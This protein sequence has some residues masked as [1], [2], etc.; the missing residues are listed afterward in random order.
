[1]AQQP[2]QPATRDFQDIL[3]DLDEGRVHSH[4]TEH[5]R[6]VV[7]AVME[8]GKVGAL[9]LKVNVRRENR[10]AVVAAAITTKIPQ[11]PTESTVFFTTVDGDL[12]REDPLQPVLKNL[13]VRPPTPL[14]SIDGGKPVDATTTEKPGS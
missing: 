9:T 3:T 1:M 13:E 2:T 7:S 8:T 11:P 14:R 5:L 6:R 4:L 10:M 12:R